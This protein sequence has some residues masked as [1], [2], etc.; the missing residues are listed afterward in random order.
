MVS[1]K[2]IL[3]QTRQVVKEKALKWPVH[4]ASSVNSKKSPNVYKSCP[5]MISLEKLKILTPSQKLHKNVEDLWK[6]NCCQRLWKVAQSPINP[7]IWSH[8]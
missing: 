5:K 4:L 2:N 3:V 1:V 8:W 6:I 7:Q